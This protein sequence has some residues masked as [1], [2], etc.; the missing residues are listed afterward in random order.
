MQDLDYKAIGARIK[1]QR[2]YLGLTRDYLSDQL[3]V[4]VTFC[5][6]FEIGAKGISI[7]TLAG[8]MYVLKLSADYILFGETEGIDTEPLLRMLDSCP[9]EKRKYAEDILK[10][11]LMAM[12]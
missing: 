6:D 1:K 7:Q 2:E 5:R 12:E 9:P 8:L 10:A 4:S 11:F 3:G